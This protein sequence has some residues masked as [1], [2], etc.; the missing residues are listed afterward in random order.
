M[1]DDSLKLLTFVAIAVGLLYI[2]FFSPWA[3]TGRIISWKKQIP[4]GEAKEG[5]EFEVC[6]I[7]NLARGYV[8]SPLSNKKCLYYHIV[9]KDNRRGTSRV[10]VDVFEEEKAVDMLLFDGANYA[11]VDN[12]DNTYYVDKEGIRSTSFWSAEDPELLRFLKYKGIKLVAWSG[13]TKNLVVTER[14]IEV[15]ET[16]TVFGSGR[17]CNPKELKLKLDA[18]KVL[19]I[20][21]RYGTIPRITDDP[22]SA[23]ILKG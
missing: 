12:V 15:G 4:I 3:L 10:P 5:E 9:V 20:S 7:A 23:K 1:E 8:Y 19:H 17:W 18:G 16:V 13:F 22:Y 14:L 6:G 2:L 11:L 21:A